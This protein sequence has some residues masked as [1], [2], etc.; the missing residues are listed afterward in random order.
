M[1]TRHIAAG[2][3]LA[4]TALGASAQTSVTL[5]GLLDASVEYARHTAGATAGSG[6]ALR[7]QPG[8]QAGSRWGL[9]GTEDLGGGLKGIFTLESG[10]DN[11]TGAFNTQGAPGVGF[12]RRAFVGVDKAGLGQV[13]LGRDYT[14]AFWVVL[15][16]DRMQRG[17]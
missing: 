1:K 2:L 9:T 17:L 5:Y 12:T 16:S 14:P 13:Y 3:V 10:I 15:N 4:G 6:S 11:D 8:V 7:V